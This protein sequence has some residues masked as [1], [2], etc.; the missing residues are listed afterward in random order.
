MRPVPRL[1]PGSGARVR[2]DLSKRRDSQLMNKN[3]L[4]PLEVRPSLLNSLTNLVF[5]DGVSAGSAKMKFRELP[6]FSAIFTNCGG[7]KIREFEPTQ[8]ILHTH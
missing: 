3:L 6:R 5:V 7:S 8:T 4:T 1:V 2:C